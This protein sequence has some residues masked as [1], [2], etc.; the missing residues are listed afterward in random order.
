MNAICAKCAP[1]KNM[2][3]G[4][5]YRKKPIVNRDV[6]PPHSN[7]V[8]ACFGLDAYMEDSDIRLGL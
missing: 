6:F 7:N 8:S 1:I 4:R 3:I 5:K 2:I